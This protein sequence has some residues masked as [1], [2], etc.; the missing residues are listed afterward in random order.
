[1]LIDLFCEILVKVSIQLEEGLLIFKHKIIALTLWVRH[2]LY[3]GSVKVKP[4]LGFGESLINLTSYLLPVSLGTV[5]F[6][7]DSFRPVLMPRRLIIIA[8]DAIK[9]PG[10]M[11]GTGGHCAVVHHLLPPAALAHFLLFETFLDPL[12]IGDIHHLYRI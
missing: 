12:E 10:L 7:S 4:I 11:V 8:E 3:E 1:M 2:D 9:W 6:N 5:S